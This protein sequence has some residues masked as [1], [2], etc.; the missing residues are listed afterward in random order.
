MLDDISVKN[1]IF[2]FRK[3]IS[4]T[5]NFFQIKFEHDEILLLYPKFLIIKD[6]LFENFQ[7][8]SD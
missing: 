3:M 5:K 7:Y 4:N 2:G 6:S 1:K 8:I